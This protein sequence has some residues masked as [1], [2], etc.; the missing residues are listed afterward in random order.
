METKNLL[1]A[2]IDDD[3]IY[4]FTSTLLLQKINPTTQIVEFSDGELALN[5]FRELPAEG[6][7]WPDIVL[8]DINMPILD[9]WSFLELVQVIVNK[10]S[11]KP[12]F[13]MV[14][15]SIDPRDVEKVKDYPALQGYLEK[16]LDYDKMSDLMK[17]VR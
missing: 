12:A 6:S 11:Q 7:A 8:I 3:E 5:Y 13:F 17:L 15:S 14:S 1:I 4:R 10:P 2:I 16:P 9:G